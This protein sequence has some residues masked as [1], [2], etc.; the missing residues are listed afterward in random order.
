VYAVSIRSASSHYSLA[1]TQ[2]GKHGQAM[3]ETTGSGQYNGQ[4]VL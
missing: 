2:T 3:L 1:L 4:V